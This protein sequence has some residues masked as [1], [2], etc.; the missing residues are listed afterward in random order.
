M[1]IC[2]GR[3]YIKI[4]VAFIVVT[5]SGQTIGADEPMI[6]TVYEK[7]VAATVYSLDA[8]QVSRKLLSGH[9]GLGTVTSP[10]NITLGA[11]SRCGNVSSGV[12]RY[13]SSWAFVRFVTLYLRG[14]GL[15]M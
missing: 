15:M 8:R 5:I 9:L 11:D 13:S 1:Q 6:N 3:L 4:A 7:N 12:R 14:K 2:S 10:N